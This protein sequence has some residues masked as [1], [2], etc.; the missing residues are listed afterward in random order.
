MITKQAKANRPRDFEYEND[1]C[2]LVLVTGWTPDERLWE[3]DVLGF[4]FG[5]T[6]VFYIAIYDE[7]VNAFIAYPLGGHSI[8]KTHIGKLEIY[9]NVF[10]F[11]IKYPEYRELITSRWP[12]VAFS[13]NLEFYLNNA[14]LSI[15][16]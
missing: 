12:Y 2:H 6:N 3:H 7:T 8:G 15:Y 4:K 16:R 9:E 1:D 14:G 5:W 11:Y 10:D 13:K